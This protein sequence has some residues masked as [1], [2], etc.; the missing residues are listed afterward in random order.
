MKTK[1][2]GRTTAYEHKHPDWQTKRFQ[3]TPAIHRA[4]I[5]DVQWTDCPVEVEEAVKKLWQDYDLGN[6]N[7]YFNW[8]GDDLGAHAT[9]Y[10]IIHEYL[11][12]NGVKRCLIHWWW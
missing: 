9:H 11:K 1:Y 8:D 12:S 3:T 2:S 10:P 4:T 6:D 7:V 5:F